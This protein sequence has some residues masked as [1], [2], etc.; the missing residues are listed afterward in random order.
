[1]K[2][3]ILTIIGTRPEIIKMYPIINKI[4]KF[5][6]NKLVWSGQ[7]YDFNMV[8][9]IFIDVNLRRPDYFIKLP[10]KK[11]HLFEIQREIYKIITKVKPKAI[12]Y[13]GDTFTTLASALVANFFFYKI[14]KI[15]IEGGYR[16]EDK[17]QIEERARLIVDHLSDHNFVA[18]EHQKE[19]LL[20][21]NIKKNIHVVG[22]SVTDSVNNILNK[23]KKKIKFKCCNP[24]IEKFI[25]VTI[26]RSE[27]VDDDKKLI[28]IFQI[29]NWL[30]NIYKIIFS[31]HPRT[32]KRLKQ[33][34]I[35]LKSNVILTKPL[36]Y[37]HSI[38]LISK[39]FFCFSDSGGVQ[40]E[41]IILKKRCLI[42]SNKT[43]HVHYLDKNANQLIDI[44]YNKFLPQIKKFI[45]SIK[46]N[47]PKKYTHKRRTSQSIASIISRI[48]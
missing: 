23:N 2:K 12:I 9:N 5:Y 29:I 16:S 15:H 11:I 24:E 43:P 13:H 22:N 18:M 3:K 42:P 47:T 28:K 34:K 31:I 27:N 19:N 6:D 38:Y 32:H 10:K 39:C 37:S 45:I 17:N 40:E 14:I 41:A 36:S 21:E 1:M 26:H 4:D 30:S 7:H 48:V 35:K 25:Y 44:K 33:F 20:K 8:K 46:K